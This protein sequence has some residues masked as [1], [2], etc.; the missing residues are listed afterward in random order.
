MVIQDLSLIPIRLRF[1]RLP[2]NGNEIIISAGTELPGGYAFKVGQEGSTVDM[3]SEDGTVT[4]YTVV[5][6]CDNFNAA[7]SDINYKAYT[8]GNT[9][10]GM[11]KCI[12]NSHCRAGIIM[13]VLRSW[14][15]G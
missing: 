10:K 15:K 5:G 3:L 6:V 11:E 2:K 13:P 12:C 14:Q 8:Y 9:G 4:S 7:Q 1:G